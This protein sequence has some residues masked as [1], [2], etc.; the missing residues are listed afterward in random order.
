MIKHII[1]TVI[2][3][4]PAITWAFYKPVRILAPELVSDIK[5]SKA[6]ICLDDMSRYAE[7]TRLYKEAI[8]FVASSIGGIKKKPLIIFCSTESCF[9]SFGF[10]KSTANTIGSSGIIISPRGWKPYYIRHEIIHHLQAKKM[11]VISQWQSPE[12]FKEGMAYSLSGDPR[13]K[14]ELGDKLDNFRTKF[15]AWY[16]SINRENIWELSK[17]L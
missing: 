4:S 14:L 13:N 7:A 3:L 16:K 17:Q 10:N 6:S 12:W 15:N 1:I 9:N 8:E 11:G 2:L 5:C